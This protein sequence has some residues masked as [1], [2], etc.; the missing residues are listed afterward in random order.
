M[1]DTLSWVRSYWL[2]IARSEVEACMGR[3][4]LPVN[5]RWLELI[6]FS[7]TRKR[8]MFLWSSTEE[9]SKPPKWNSL[10]GATD[11]SSLMGPYRVIGG[12]PQNPVGRTGMKSRG[13][14]GKWGPNHAADPVVT[15]LWL[16]RVLF[17]GSAYLLSM[18]TF[19]TLNF[20]IVSMSSCISYRWKRDDNGAVVKNRRSG[21]PVL[22]CVLIQRKDNGE[23]AL[24]GVRRRPPCVVVSAKLL[25]KLCT[26]CIYFRAWST[27]ATT[28]RSLF[29]KSLPKK[30]WTASKW[31]NATR[32]TSQNS[33]KK[34]S[35]TAIRFVMQA[36]PQPPFK[37]MIYAS[38]KIPRFMHC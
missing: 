30:Q 12:L 21:K 15:R 22:Q 26:S 36:L 34:S 29:A 24:P 14:L 7:N 13:T 27:R 28:F 17:I 1:G 2:H 4:W 37:P 10:D 9:G 5:I 23:W 3:P 20:I 31:T 6:A 38:N 8:V 32:N 33:S 35:K 25:K 19:A 18:F 11:R 16:H